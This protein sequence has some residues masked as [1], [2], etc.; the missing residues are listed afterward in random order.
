MHQIRRVD[1]GWIA[2]HA[3]SHLWTSPRPTAEDAAAAAG[4]PEGEE[5]WHSGA[6]ETA[7]GEQIAEPPACADSIPADECL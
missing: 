2:R 3:A 6:R 4:I 7:D 1:D 5:C